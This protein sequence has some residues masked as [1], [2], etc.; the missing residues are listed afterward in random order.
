[1]LVTFGPPCFRVHAFAAHPMQ[2]RHACNT[3][4]LIKLGSGSNTVQHQVNNATAL[5]LEVAA[6]KQHQGC[7]ATA[8]RLEVARLAFRRQ[9]T[10]KLRG[11]G[12]Q[13]QAHE[14]ALK[15]RRAKHAHAQRCCCHHSCSIATR[16][17]QR[18]TSTRGGNHGVV[19]GGE[20]QHRS[21]QAARSR[22]ATSHV[23][24]MSRDI[25]VTCPMLTH[26]TRANHQQ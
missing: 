4:A 7:N 16:H 17:P 19:G 23:T 21:Q 25:H 22:P 6:T 18:F 10:C 12:C 20:G 11:G 14:C 15:R 26:K 1:M 3:T 13:Q 2:L 5:S 9:H 24:Y 8:L